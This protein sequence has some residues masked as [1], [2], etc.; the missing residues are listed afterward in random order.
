MITASEPKTGDQIN[1]CRSSHSPDPPSQTARH[2]AGCDRPARPAGTTSTNR[3]ASRRSRRRGTGRRDAWMQN[4]LPT[5]PHRPRTRASSPRVPS[6]EAFRRG[7]RPPQR[8][9]T[10]Q[11]GPA[12]ETL[13]KIG[14]S[15][16]RH[17]VSAMRRRTDLQLH[18][19]PSVGNA[20]FCR[21]TLSR[22]G[23][24]GL[25]Q[26]PTFNGEHAN[27]QNTQLF[28]NEELAFLWYM[29]NIN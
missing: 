26:L 21:P 12:S 10:S 14:S 16:R 4:V 9:L 22:P 18:A 15:A 20:T 11:R 24:S 19:A 3:Q 23:A 29:R 17:S 25:C 7:P 27:G 1:A 28:W 2:Y 5:N 8:K 13:H 6:L